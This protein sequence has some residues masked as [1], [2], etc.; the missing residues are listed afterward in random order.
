MGNCYTHVEEYV[1]SCT[2]IV[3][4]IGSDRYEGS[5]A[6]FAKLAEKHKKDF[7]TVDI[8]QDMPRRL[9][10]AIPKHLPYTFVQC[11][12]TEWTTT[13]TR[14]ISIL[15]LDNF[16]WDWEVGTKSKMIEEQRLWYKE[17]NI[18]M[19]NMESQLAHLRQ[20]KNLLPFMTQ[21]CVICIDDTYKHNGVYIGKGGAVVPYLLVNNF[22]IELTQ[23]YGVIMSKIL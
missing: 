10:K 5:S 15:Y 3:L 14:P 13:C 16:D 19:N 12:G 18:E 20:M 6:Y 9:H 1:Q 4:E 23:D 22:K 7:V 11:E 2:G 17:H 8:D 21:Q